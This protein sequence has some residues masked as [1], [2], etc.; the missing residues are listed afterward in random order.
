MKKR[1]IV[2]V[3][4][5]LTLLLVGCTTRT[6][7]ANYREVRQ[8]VETDYVSYDF[9][10]LS[11]AS[12][13][14]VMGQL[15]EESETLLVKPYGG[16]DPWVFRDLTFDVQEIYKGDLK[17]ENSVAL[18][19]AGGKY[20]DEEAKIHYILEANEPEFNF[21]KRYVLFLTR[22][23]ADP[24]KTRDNYYILVTGPQSAFNVFD[25]QMVN[26][27]DPSMIYELSE[28]DTIDGTVDPDTVTKS[29]MDK[30]LKDGE[31]T[32]EDYDQYFE[33]LDQFGEK[34]N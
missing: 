34:I 8:G 18:R 26:I 4:M 30:R 11:D 32:Q 23:K 17:G 10:D 14:V 16:N 15:K 12:E 3:L 2:S 21:D 6:E 9:K 7:K 28:L 13:L 25:S 33:S 29:E 1:T 24:Y 20:T 19:L 31:M 27:E 22:P 5:V